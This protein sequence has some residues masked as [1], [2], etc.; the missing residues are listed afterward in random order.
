MAEPA[1]PEG[2]AAAQQVLLAAVD[3]NPPRQQLALRLLLQ[4][5]QATAEQVPSS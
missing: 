3:G 5:T 4:A 1:G 2:A